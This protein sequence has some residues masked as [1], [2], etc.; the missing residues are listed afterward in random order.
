MN[1]KLTVL[2]VLAI[3]VSACGV[4]L[5]T[6]GPA[7][8]EPT[9]AP[10]APTATPI[11]IAVPTATPEPTAQPTTVVET[12]PRSGSVCSVINDYQ[13]L[14]LPEVSVEPDGWLH[15]ETFVNG[16]PE[17]ETALPSGRYTIDQSLTDGGHVWEYAP[18]CTID[19]VLT[20][21]TAHIAR[22]VEL[23]AKNGGYVHYQEYIDSGLFTVVVMTGVPDI[24][25]ALPQ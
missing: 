24:P 15:V 23:K 6:Q 7:T 3:L 12:T 2:L 16:Q 25:E 9:E 20:Q 17:Y 22:R 8:P 5:P 1:K 18:E 21:M 4:V 19:E 14:D 10:A 11:V 13:L